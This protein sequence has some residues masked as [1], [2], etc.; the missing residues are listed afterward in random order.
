MAHRASVDFPH[1]DSPTSPAVSPGLTRRSTPRTALDLGPPAQVG[2]HK[3]LAQSPDF[4]GRNHGDS[5]ARLDAGR[6]MGF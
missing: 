5:L 1:P 2:G 3:R 4:E 6:P